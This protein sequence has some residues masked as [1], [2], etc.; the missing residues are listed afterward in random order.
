MENPKQSINWHVFKL[1][2]NNIAIYN[3]NVMISLFGIV[4]KSIHNFK[5]MILQIQLEHGNNHSMSNTL[6]SSKLVFVQI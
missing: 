5:F 4:E 1:D 6:K 2:D 3:Y